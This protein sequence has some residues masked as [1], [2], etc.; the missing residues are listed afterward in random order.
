[1]PIL[2]ECVHMCGCPHKSTTWSGH[3]PCSSPSKA[4]ECLS[5]RWLA[6]QRTVWL[7][8]SPASCLVSCGVIPYPLCSPLTSQVLF[9]CHSALFTPTHYSHLNSSITSLEEEA[10][11]RSAAAGTGS[12]GTTFSLLVAC[13]SPPPGS[14]VITTHLLCSCLITLS[15]SRL[16]APR[17]RTRSACSPC[18]PTSGTEPTPGTGSR[19]HLLHE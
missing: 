3:S 9:S 12:R 2:H 14:L 4:H 13:F 5:L 1:M 7:V 8:L 17:G 18:H 10:C 16:K 6:E 15:S 19:R 11:L